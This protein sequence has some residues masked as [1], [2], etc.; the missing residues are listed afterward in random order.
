MRNLRHRGT[1]LKFSYLVSDWARIDR[2]LWWLW[3]LWFSA[4]SVSGRQSGP[5]LPSLQGGP[6]APL[7][8]Q[9]AAAPNREQW[10][11]SFTGILPTHQNT[12]SRSLNWFS[13]PVGMPGGRHARLLCLPYRKWPGR[14][15]LASSARWQENYHFLKAIT[16]SR[17][18]LSHRVLKLF[19]PQRWGGKDNRNL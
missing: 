7:E 12:G 16:L 8:T 6:P 13:V 19:T 15:P 14:R 11:P 3:W 9:P 18:C 5:R 10:P 2:R 1:L 17:N 4:P